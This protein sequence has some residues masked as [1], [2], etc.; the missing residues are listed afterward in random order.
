MDFVPLKFI[1]PLSNF[2]YTYVLIYLLVGAGIYFT[3][4]TKGRSVPVFRPDGQ[5]DLQFAAGQRG[6]DL[7]I[8]GVRR[9]T[10]FTRRYRQHRWRGDSVD[11]RWT[12]GDFLDVG[13]RGTR[14][15]NRVIAA[16]A[17]V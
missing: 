12:G 1:D 11:P 15:G 17:S 5:A 3:I 16:L 8:P 9:R 14:D 13:R 7:L 2:L 10:G 4:R 6:R